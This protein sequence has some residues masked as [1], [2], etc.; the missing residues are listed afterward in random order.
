[1]VGSEFGVKNM[2]GVD[3]SCLESAVQA[4]GGGVM[5]WVGMQRLNRFTINRAL[6]CH[7]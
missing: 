1:M 6:K 7:G 2:K 4:G 3:P 5:V